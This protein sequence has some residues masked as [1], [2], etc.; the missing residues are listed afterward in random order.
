MNWLHII[1]REASSRIAALYEI[2]YIPSTFIIDGKGK[3]VA[4]N[5]RGTELKNKIAACLK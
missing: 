5:L 1:D 4:R 2:E 3:I